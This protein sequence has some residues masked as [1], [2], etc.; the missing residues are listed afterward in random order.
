MDVGA[1]PAQI[2]TAPPDSNSW[3]LGNRR[4]QGP[5]EKMTEVALR[6]TT[7]TDNPQQLHSYVVHAWVR[8]PREVHFLCH[9]SDGL[10]FVPL[11]LWPPTHILHNPDSASTEFARPVN[12]SQIASKFLKT[13]GS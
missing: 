4:G 5:A 3:S 6:S 10:S 9:G 8:I 7:V 1:A 2:P 13:A 11:R 12:R